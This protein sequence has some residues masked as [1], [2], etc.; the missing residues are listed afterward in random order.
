[1][2]LLAHTSWGQAFKCI[3]AEQPVVLQLILRWKMTVGSVSH[4]RT[5]RD[6]EADQYLRQISSV[7]VCV[8]VCVCVCVVWGGDVFTWTWSSVGWLQNLSSFIHW[9]IQ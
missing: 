2:V 8:S 3:E 9:A 4:G 7:S 6:E 5:A 1:M